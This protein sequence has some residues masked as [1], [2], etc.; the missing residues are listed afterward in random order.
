M[1]AAS[2]ADSGAQG[3]EP[4]KRNLPEP[5]LGARNEPAGVAGPEQHRGGVPRAEPLRL[6]GR[7]QHLLPLRRAQS[8]RRRGRPGIPAQLLACQE[9]PGQPGQQPAAERAA[10]PERPAA[11]AARRQLADE[12]GREAADNSP[13]LRG[14][15]AA[16]GREDLRMHALPALRRRYISPGLCRVSAITPAR[17][18]ARHQP[19]VPLRWLRADPGVG[20][21]G[22]G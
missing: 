17:R 16:E 2:G 12:L 3:G 7:P 20:R 11:H 9:P 21:R 1:R 18:A 14:D 15:W 4:D 5:G 13:G 10:R 6:P 19:A 8:R 22:R